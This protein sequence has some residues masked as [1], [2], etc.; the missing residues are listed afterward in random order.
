MFAQCWCV[1][2]HSQFL[3]Y[4]LVAAVKP[5]QVFQDSLMFTRSWCVWLH[6]QFLEYDLVAD[7]S[8]VR[9]FRTLLR[10]HGAGV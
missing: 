2:L 8:L 9:C 3:E 7:V 6:S 1:W 4:D 5:C 10:L